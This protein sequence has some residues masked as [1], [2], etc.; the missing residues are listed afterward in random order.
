M[1]LVLRLV[2]AVLI[3]IGGSLPSADAGVPMPSRS[4]PTVHDH[5]A[6]VAHAHAASATV[7]AKKAASSDGGRSAGGH[8]TALLGGCCGPIESGAAAAVPAFEK[9]DVAWLPRIEPD[10]RDRAAEPAT[11][12]P[13]A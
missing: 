6:H 12:P 10:I 7:E 1:K 9:I 4:E 11:P 5:T 8:C 2:F 13:R 3:A